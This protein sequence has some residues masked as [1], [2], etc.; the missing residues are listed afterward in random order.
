MNK[1]SHDEKERS[2]QRIIERLEAAF[3]G[4]IG[5]SVSG[6]FSPYLK[7]EIITKSQIEAYDEIMLY[8]DKFKIK[9]P[10]LLSILDR[11]MTYLSGEKGRQKNMENLT[12]EWLLNASEEQLEQYK[13]ALLKRAQAQQGKRGRLDPI[14]RAN[15]ALKNRMEAAGYYSRMLPLLKQVSPTYADHMSRLEALN[16]KI[17]SE[18]GLRYDDDGYVIIENSELNNNS[19]G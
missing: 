4:N 16:E 19:N 10:L 3:P 9:V 6:H 7:D 15:I 17:C 14:E 5:Y 13:K 8:L 2:P 18:L 1:S 12:T 11:Y